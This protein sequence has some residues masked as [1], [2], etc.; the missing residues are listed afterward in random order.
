MT[1]LVRP[2]WKECILQG[3]ERGVNSQ[4]IGTALERYFAKKLIRVH[5]YVPKISVL[6]IKF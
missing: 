2:S 6:L 1:K 3:W 5:E 4:T